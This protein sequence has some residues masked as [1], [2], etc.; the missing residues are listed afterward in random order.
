M[1]SFMV[2]NGSKMLLLFSYLRFCVNL[3]MAPRLHSGSFRGNAFLG[4]CF[5]WCRHNSWAWCW[6]IAGWASL[7]DHDPL[8]H[9]PRPRG[10]CAWWED[11]PQGKACS[12]RATHCRC[13]WRGDGATNTV[14]N[15]QTTR[16]CT[17]AKSSNVLT[18]LWCQFWMGCRY[19][20]GS[21]TPGSTSRAQVLKEKTSPTTI[22]CQIRVTNTAE[23]TAETST[24][25][26]QPSVHK[27]TLMHEVNSLSCFFKPLPHPFDIGHMEAGKRQV[28]VPGS[29]WS[30]CCL[31]CIGWGWN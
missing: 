12:T 13:R 7:K 20:G 5:G 31:C 16:W 9:W 2:D 29:H 14:A 28:H 22:I 26:H 27:C 23:R 10:G 3:Q 11:A 4:F 17:A 19:P 15:W 30:S 18:L 1:C 21:C 24:R 6:S 25:G 8:C